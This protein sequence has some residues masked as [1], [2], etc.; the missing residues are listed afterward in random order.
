VSGKRYDL[1]DHPEF[2]PPLWNIV[3]DCDYAE[4]VW[5]LDA[6]LNI[7]QIT[8]DLHFLLKRVA[9]RKDADKTETFRR[10]ILELLR[11]WECLGIP[12]SQKTFNWVASELERLWWPDRQAEKQR[13]V[14][15]LRIRVD[16]AEAVHRH[17]GI[18]RPRHAAYAMVAKAYGHNS[19]GALRKA[20][21]PNRVNRKP[22]RKPRR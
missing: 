18:K 6:V 14:E 13:R 5:L 1:L 19:G 9:L 11:N 4:H 16:M 7:G 3:T 20:L 8:P 2:G 21:Q 15:E 12:V 22:R 17:E 10:A